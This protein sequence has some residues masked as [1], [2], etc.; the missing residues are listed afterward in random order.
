M[1]QA[2]QEKPSLN[3]WIEGGR[4]HISG[5][6]AVIDS[7]YLDMMFAYWNNRDARW[8]I[9]GRIRR[10]DSV[11]YHRPAPKFPDELISQL[12]PMQAD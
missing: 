12:R 4:P 5:R 9:N 6:Y 7:V 1:S 2:E 11:L 8:S 10:A 3:G